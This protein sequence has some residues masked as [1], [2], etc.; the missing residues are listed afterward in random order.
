MRS[1]KC[2]GAFAC[3]S[4]EP[5]ASFFTSMFF[6]VSGALDATL[7]PQ[8][9]QVPSSF[10]A[11]G[12]QYLAQSSHQGIAGHSLRFRT[13]SLMGVEPNS[14]ASRMER[15][16]YRRYVAGNSRFTNSVKVGGS[17]APCRA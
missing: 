17:V 7:R 3:S 11:D 13:L 2:H 1:L 15:S 4:S 8:V 9:G 12:V 10:M 14:N 5:A 16:R 6:A